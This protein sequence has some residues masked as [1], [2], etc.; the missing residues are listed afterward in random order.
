MALLGADCGEIDEARRQLAEPANTVTSPNDLRGACSW[1][2]TP[3][4]ALVA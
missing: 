1:T 4:M 2:L 3:L